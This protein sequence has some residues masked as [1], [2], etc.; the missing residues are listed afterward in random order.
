MTQRFEALNEM[1]PPVRGFIAVAGS[2]KAGGPQQVCAGGESTVT[3]E[4][5]LR[6]L[7]DVDHRHARGR[8]SVNDCS[9]EERALFLPTGDSR[10][11]ND[12]VASL[13]VAITGS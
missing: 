4:R 6:G 13:D 2:L 1:P 12:V 9:D 5:E 8:I 7:Q 3:A 10:A 11:P